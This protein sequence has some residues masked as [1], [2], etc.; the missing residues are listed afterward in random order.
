[1]SENYESGSGTLE[2]S[3]TPE[4]NTAAGAE[5]NDDYE[6]YSDCTFEVSGGEEG[7]DSEYKE[8]AQEDYESYEECIDETSEGELEMEDESGEDY[9]DCVEAGEAE[10]PEETSEDEEASEAEE[11]DAGEAEGLDA[12]EVTEAEEANEAEE[13]NETEKPDAEEAR[14]VE[15]SEA[16]AASMS[17]Q[18]E[19]LEAERNDLDKAMDEKFN[20]L[21]TTDMRDGSYKAQLTEYNAMKDR[22][23]EL[24]EQIESLREQQVKMEEKENN[25]LEAL[26]KNQLENVAYS[27]GNNELGYLGTCGPT[28]VANSL[29]I[30][31]NSNRF[32]ENAVLEE[33]VDSNLCYQ[34]ANPLEA[35]GTGT[36]QVAQLIENV[37]GSEDN[38]QV[39]VYEYSNALSTEELAERLKDS[40][41]VAIVG[42]DSA[43][44]WDESDE[45]TNSGLFQMNPSDHW[46]TVES[47]VYGDGEQLMGFRVVD[48]GGG[49]DYVDADKFEQMYKGDDTHK[50]KDPTAILISNKGGVTQPTNNTT[51]LKNNI[52]EAGAQ[53]NMRQEYSESPYSSTQKTMI[54][55]SSEITESK[56][57]VLSEEVKEKLKTE[58]DT[59]VFWSG[60]DSADENNVRIPGDKNAAEYAKQHGGITLE[61]VLETKEIHMPEWDVDDEV[62]VKT[63]EAVSASYAEQA[64]GEVRAYVGENLR[65]GNI[66]ENEELPRL[67]MNENV[68]KITVINPKT[69][70]SETIFSRSNGNI[71]VKVNEKLQKSGKWEETMD[72]L[73]QN[74]SVKS[75]SYTGNIKTKIYERK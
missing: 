30:V 15:T 44:L 33:A 36:L 32:S 25:A 4:V 6:D 57:I 55:A 9:S 42:V 53:V 8:A 52:S 13:S 75:I 59:A 31:T 64:S 37:R 65:E 48:S 43:I 74:S 16:E 56:K 20:S 38:L 70:E 69:G 68:E 3:E 10:T 50:V 24:E 63:W 60:C 22:K 11:S 72:N 5:V 66:W 54:N 28:S 17:Q 67:M 23:S 71:E 45:V 2:N 58:P 21:I 49:V 12:E 14:E 47:P 7:T 46:I 27:Q 19:D 51:F 41:T 62:S 39:E 29:N 1:M 40:D 18:I 35:G 26:S 73:K 61:T 34:S